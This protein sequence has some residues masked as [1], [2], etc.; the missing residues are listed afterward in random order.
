MLHLGKYIENEFFYA[1]SQKIKQKEQKYNSISKFFKTPERLSIFKI[2]I[3][4]QPL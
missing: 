1:I 3:L 2:L 4:I